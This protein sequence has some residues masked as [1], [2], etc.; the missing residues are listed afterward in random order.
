VL[1]NSI[2][3]SGTHLLTATLR[4][5]P[6]MMFSGVQHSLS[7]FIVPPRAGEGRPILD[8]ERLE[9]VLSAVHGGQFVIAHFPANDDL[10]QILGDLGYR[11]ALM[12]RDPRD[13]VVSHSFYV[14]ARPDH[15]LHQRYRDEMSSDE[16]RLL[17]SITGLPSRDGLG[18]ESIGR[19]LEGY[20]AWTSHADT[21]VF[22]FES[23]VGP[24]GGGSIEEQ[25]REIAALAR[26][27]R[28]PLTPAQLDRIGARIWS[29][30]AA[31]FRRGRIGDWRNHFTEEHKAA[32]KDV[33][34]QGLI[35][36]G[37][38]SDLSW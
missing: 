32:F 17:A 12:M 19:R 7:E 30:S 31:T 36:L 22:R 14:V 20:L 18:L 6:Q 23:I 38:E 24:Q 8:R 3:K 33:A 16:E 10:V 11:C 37:Y 4:R 29:G 5:L 28:R 27:L 21:R 34:G 1:A 26:H 35:R 2:P 15:H 25:R 9:G 13:V